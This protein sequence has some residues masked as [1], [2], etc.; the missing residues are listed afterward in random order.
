MSIKTLITI[1]VL[2]AAVVTASASTR[3]WRFIVTCDS[4]GTVTGINEPVLTELAGEIARRGADFVLYP[5]DLVY[6][7]RIP[8]ERFESELRQWVG[9][10]RPVY[11]AGIPVYVCRGNHEIG[12][13]WDAEVDEHPDPFDNYGI[14]WLRVFGDQSLPEV[15]L[16]D[17]GPPGG[18]HLTY[19]VRHKNALIV[20]LDQYGG[21][22]YRLEHGVNQPWLDSELE[23]NTKPHVFVFGHEPA[24]RT[25]HPDCLDAHPAQRDAFWNSLKRAGGRTYF[26]GHDHYYDHAV[27]DDGD[28]DPGNDVHQLIVATAG[29]PFYEWNPPY[30]G[31]NGDFTV[32]Q[33]FHVRRYGYIVVDVDGLNVTL[34][35][36]QRRD[37][38]MSAPGAYEAAEVWGYAVAA[39]PVLVAPNG[40]ERVI[41]GRP[42]VLRW[43]TVEGVDVKQVVLEYSVDDG[44]SW[45]FID[46]VDNGGA[47]EWIAPMLNSAQCWLRVRDARDPALADTSDAAFSI[48]ECQAKLAA[49]LNGDCYV[50]ATDAAILAMEWLKC[51]NPLDPACDPAK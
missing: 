12:D 29:A 23:R 43:K 26:C 45:T 33:L 20:A 31:D 18:E 40:G 24:F 49:D 35:W 6:G 7:A 27:V 14:R 22:D 10:M 8:A 28:G 30:L 41:A 32:Q 21:R 11:Q 16:P 1:L 47:Y 2:H 17:N 50:D 44:A 42:Y 5:G 13:M 15:M 46:E 9:I 48:F 36:M 19:A 4:R 51:G 3:S 39:G 34:T 37:N 38:D 25:F